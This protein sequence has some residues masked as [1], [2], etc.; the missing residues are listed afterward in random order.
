MLL[1]TEIITQLAFVNNVN[2]EESTAVRLKIVI[3]LQNFPP[4][5]A[6]IKASS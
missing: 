4:R 2:D 3:I 5:N 6:T 1:S